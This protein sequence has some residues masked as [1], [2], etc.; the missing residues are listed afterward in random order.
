MMYCSNWADFWFDSAALAVEA[1][2]VINLRMLKLAGFD[3]PAL[4]EA[5]LMVTEKVATAFELNALVMTGGLG[6]SPSSQARG[7]VRRLRSKVASNRRRLQRR[8]SR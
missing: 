7:T 8:P 6:Q 3:G 2:E 5:Q 4:H 1:G